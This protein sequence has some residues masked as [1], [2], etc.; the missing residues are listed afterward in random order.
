MTRT[1]RVGLILVG[2]WS[3]RPPRPRPTATM[4]AARSS[5]GAQPHPH[6][7]SQLAAHAQPR[8]DMRLKRVTAHRAAGGASVRRGDPDR[9]PD[10][11]QLVV[12]G[13]QV[14]V[15]AAQHPPGIPVRLTPVAGPAAGESQPRVLLKLWR[16][17]ATPMLRE[18]V[19]RPHR[20]LAQPIGGELDAGSTWRLGVAGGRRRLRL[21]ASR[22][23]VCSAC[24][25]STPR[26]AA[27]CSRSASRD[28][29]VRGRSA[30]PQS[31]PIGR[32]TPTRA[33]K[34]AGFRRAARMV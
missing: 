34:R 30:R 26:L 31:Y 15:G 16:D 18:R 13:R 29:A 8:R 11:P 9:D 27:V 10:Q 32:T 19:D 2:R 7:T 12:A 22:S 20:R 4:T 1:S 5:R 21:R 25:W 23:A 24:W 33:G 6:P 17:V 14:E 28:M 3:A